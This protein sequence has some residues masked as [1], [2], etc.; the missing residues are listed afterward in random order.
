MRFLHNRYI[1]A[2]ILVVVLILTVVYGTYPRLSSEQWGFDQ[3]SYVN[4][5]PTLETVRAHD[6]LATW[7]TIPETIVIAGAVYNCGVHIDA[8]FENI[9]AITTLF[10]DYHLLIAY[11]ESPDNTLEKLEEWKLKLPQMTLLKGRKTSRR[12]TDNLVIARN[13]YLETM[14]KMYVTMLFPY[15]IV[16]DFDDVCSEPI[17]LTVLQYMLA[18]SSKWE[19]LSFP[20]KNSYYDIWALSCAPYWLSYLHFR[21]PNRALV[22]AKNFILRELVK[23]EWIPVHSAF[24]GFA[25]YKSDPFL[26]CTYAN[27]FRQNLSFL[28]PA[29]IQAHEQ[30]VVS[31]MLPT[32]AQTL[33]KWVADDDC[34]HRYFH[35]QAT[36]GHRARMY[37]VPVALFAYVDAL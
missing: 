3:K 14:R 25:V 17:R 7:A 34:E 19:A 10:R 27:S 32:W 9:R 8:V 24:G 20:G 21:N 12:R 31:R 11:D 33:R 26:K 30:A 18:Q 23:G 29:M 36:F 35:F 5:P 4:I 37:I 15:F 16:M 28:T 1:L 13:R 22:C 2:V 6:A